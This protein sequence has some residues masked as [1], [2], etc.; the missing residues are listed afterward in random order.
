MCYILCLAVPKGVSDVGRYFD[1]D[2]SL[3]SL[4]DEPIVRAIIGDHPEREA[5]AV[6]LK[7]CSCDVLVGGHRAAGRPELVIEGLTKLLDD[8]PAAAV[9]NH[10]FTRAIADAD[11]KCSGEHPTTIARFNELYPDLEDDVRYIIRK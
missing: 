2:L 6:T 9:L 3:D 8:V 10:W 5:Y 4:S 7:G 1:A 11:V